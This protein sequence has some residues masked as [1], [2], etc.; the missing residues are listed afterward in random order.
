M[1]EAEL[2]APAGLY[3]HM[4]TNLCECVF[5]LMLKLENLHEGAFYSVNG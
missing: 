3:V 5:S 2:C 4:Y 1:S